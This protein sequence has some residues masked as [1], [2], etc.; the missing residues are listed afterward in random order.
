MGS[1]VLTVVNVKITVCWNVTAC[2]FASTRPHVITFEQSTILKFTTVITFNFIVSMVWLYYSYLVGTCGSVVVKALRYKQQ[3]CY[4][5]MSVAAIMWQLL[6]HCL[7]TAVPAGFP[8]LAFSRHTT[9]L[10][11]IYALLSK[12]S[13]PRRFPNQTLLTSSVPLFLIW[14][15]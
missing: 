7:A 11:Y 12:Q 3:V 4:H 8:V 6:S 14:S 15:S 5:C 9:G 10:S 2:C 1:A 13:L